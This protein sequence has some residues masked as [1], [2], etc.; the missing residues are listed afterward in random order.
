MKRKTKNV[1]AIQIEGTKM[2]E[3]IMYIVGSKK[4]ENYDETN[5]KKVDEIK[6]LN[7]NNKANNLF[8]FTTSSS[9]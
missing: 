6:R 2:K 4:R 9:S 7:L 1:F 5:Y 3:Y 8:I